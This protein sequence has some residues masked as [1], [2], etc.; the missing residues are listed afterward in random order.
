M[1]CREIH[2]RKFRSPDFCG[3][4]EGMRLT[5]VGPTSLSFLPDD[6]MRA[7]METETVALLPVLRRIEILAGSNGPANALS[8][9]IDVFLTIAIPEHSLLQTRYVPRYSV[10]L[11]SYTKHSRISFLVCLSFIFCSKGHTFLVKSVEIMIG[12]K[13]RL[14]LCTPIE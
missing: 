5:G 12:P 14:Y 7:G 11:A 13:G 1:A 9:K 3:R 8:G 6:Q 4:L 2:L 10:C